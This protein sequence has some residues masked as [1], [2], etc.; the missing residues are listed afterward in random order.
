MLSRMSL[1][2]VLKSAG[3]KRVSKEALKEFSEILEEKLFL[4]AKE[5]ALMAKHAGRK[6]IFDEDIRLARK[7]LQI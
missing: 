1:E 3:A 4:I 7:K 5:A 2:R 6:T